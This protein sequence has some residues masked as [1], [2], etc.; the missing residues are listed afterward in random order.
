MVQG[1]GRISV[2]QGMRCTWMM[3]TGRGPRQ[4]GSCVRGY[5]LL[6]QLTD[7]RSSPGSRGSTRLQ[8]VSLNRSIPLV[9]P[10]LQIASLPRASQA[11]GLGLQGQ[12][13]LD[14]QWAHGTAEGA[15]RAVHVVSLELE[16]N[17]EPPVPDIS[18]AVPNP[19][20]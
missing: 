2:V 17:L 1:L 14:L 3:S 6:N 9:Y 8:A 4:L 10:L 7:S 5:S 19:P 13:K 18:V 12:K 11:Q 20:N 15:H 16:L